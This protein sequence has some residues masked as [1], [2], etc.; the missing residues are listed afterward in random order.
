MTEC[1]GAAFESFLAAVPAFVPVPRARDD[2][3]KRVCAIGVRSRAG[4]AT[5][6]K[7]S[8]YRNFITQN[9]GLPELNECSAIVLGW[10]RA[11]KMREFAIGSR[12]MRNKIG[13]LHERQHG[14]GA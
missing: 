2:S 7:R 14:T 9:G 13:E 5:C 1:N 8:R 3:R 12:R 10:M 4:D 11:K 6:L